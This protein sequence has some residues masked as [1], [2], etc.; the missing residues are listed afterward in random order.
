MKTSTGFNSELYLVKQSGRDGWSSNFVSNRGRHLVLLIQPG[1]FISRTETL[2]GK[3][4]FGISVRGKE[5]LEHVRFIT[6]KA[7][8]VLTWK[9][10]KNTRKESEIWRKTK[11][12][13]NE[14]SLSHTASGWP[15]Q[16]G[17]D[18][19]RSVGK[20]V[21]DVHAILSWDLGDVESSRCT[22]L[23]HLE[24]RRFMQSERVSRTCVTHPRRNSPSDCISSLCW[25][26]P[27]ALADWLFC[28]YANRAV[29]E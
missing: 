25:A 2:K 22:P 14:L 26:L 21:C 17:G 24:K 13:Q 29:H 7:A 8:Q 1:Q 28:F 20:R 16:D 23:P 27:E 6:W 15:Y 5:N 9:E 4:L 19:Q 11:K 3:E 18:D 12:R 10:V